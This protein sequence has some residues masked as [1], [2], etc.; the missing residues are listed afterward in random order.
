[1]HPFHTR[2]Q[3]AN[4]R[5]PK[6]YPQEVNEWWDYINGKRKKPK[7]SPTLI[8]NGFPEK[9]RNKPIVK[10]FCQGTRTK[11]FCDTGAEVSVIDKDFFEDLR[12]RDPKSKSWHPQKLSDVQMI[13]K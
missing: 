11:L 3:I 13:K 4:K 1:M 2:E 8:T 5:K 9:A 12:Q 6:V 7:A 10:G